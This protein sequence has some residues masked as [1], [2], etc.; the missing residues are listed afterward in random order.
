MAYFD[1]NKDTNILIDAS[2]VGSDTVLTQNGKILC[3]TSRALTD[4]E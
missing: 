3:Y 2:P 1:P 4:V